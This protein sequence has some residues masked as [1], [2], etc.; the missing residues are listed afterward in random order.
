MPS[1]KNPNGPSL[2]RLAA[3]ASTAR[4]DARK[5]STAPKGKIAKA[6]ATRGARPGLLP[7]SGPRAK[8]SAKK[9][10]K[11]EKKMGYALQR[12]NAA[13]GVVAMKGTFWG[14]GLY[15]S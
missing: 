6:D 11:L 3:R 5:R 15:E 13:E 8:L 14:L 2:N 4:K 7:T 10:R 12:K 9:A 1:I